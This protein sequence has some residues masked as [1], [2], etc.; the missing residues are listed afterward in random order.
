M[1]AIDDFEPWFFDK[2]I[3]WDGKDLRKAQIR[4]ATQQNEEKEF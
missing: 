2:D 3:F 4:R 1:I